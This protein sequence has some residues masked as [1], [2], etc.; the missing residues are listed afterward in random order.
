MSK[1]ERYDG[2]GT[3]V[4][5]VNAPTALSGVMQRER[6]KPFFFGQTKNFLKMHYTEKKKQKKAEQAPK[7]VKKVI[8]KQIP[9][10]SVTLRAEEPHVRYLKI[11]PVHRQSLWTTRIVPELRISGCWFEKAGFNM[12]SYASIT[13]MNGLLIIRS[14]QNEPDEIA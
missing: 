14:I 13:V 2:F 4:W 1:C 8:R 6:P 12:A 9:E 3:P 11:Q 7:T 10:L 5:S